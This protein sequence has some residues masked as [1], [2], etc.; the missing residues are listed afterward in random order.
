[1]VSPK[2]GLCLI[3]Q[4]RYQQGLPCTLPSVMGNK[5]CGH[6]EWKGSAAC[7][8][9]VGSFRWDGQGNLPRGWVLEL[10]LKGH[11]GSGWTQERGHS[12]GRN[13]LSKKAESVESNVFRRL[14]G[15]RVP[16]LNGE[17]TECW[18]KSLK[19]IVWAWEPMKGCQDSGRPSSSCEEGDLFYQVSCHT[20]GGQYVHGKQQ[21]ANSSS[22]KVE[23]NVKKDPLSSGVLDETC[24]LDH[25]AKTSRI[26]SSHSQQ[27]QNVVSLQKYFYRCKGRAG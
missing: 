24:L 27:P 23:V 15:G 18:F 3:T 2:Q 19:L 1:M 10:E 11:I 5:L 6:L 17:S 12:R 4:L 21:S 22:T 14:F 16:L 8:T 9:R 25:P 26:F 13:G 7:R 20:C